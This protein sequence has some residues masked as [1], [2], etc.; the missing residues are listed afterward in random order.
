[1][2]VPNRLCDHNQMPAR[3][4][5][6]AAISVLAVL[7]LSWV[8]LLVIGRESPSAGP[9]PLSTPE[10]A[11]VQ[12]GWLNQPPFQAAVEPVPAA[13][14]AEMTGV[15]WRPGCPV[16]PAQ[17]RLVRLSFRGFDNAV[18]EGELVV[19][20]DLVGAVTVAFRALYD[21]GERIHSM[22]RVERYGGEDAARAADNTFAFTC[23]PRPEG[24]WSPHAYGRAIDLNPTDHPSPMNPNDPLA[25][26]VARTGLRW[27]QDGP[28]HAHLEPAS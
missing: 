6:A 22:Q 5:L 3:R 8:V 15:S 14:V 20:A 9:G 25:A 16:D 23:T 11:F 1:M 26:T 7:S 24:G 17:L 18:H 2:E 4:V 12:P 19:H 13:V 21:N 28:E 10:G 27:V